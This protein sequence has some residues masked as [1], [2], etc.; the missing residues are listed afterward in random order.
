MQVLPHHVINHLPYGDL[1]RSQRLMSWQ[2][3]RQPSEAKHAG[4]SKQHFCDQLRIL[5]MPVIT[6]FHIMT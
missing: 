1:E 5:L 2:D 6:Y 3:V 4:H